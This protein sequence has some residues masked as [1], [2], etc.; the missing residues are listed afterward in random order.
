MRFP[1]HPGLIC[2][3]GLVAALGPVQLFG[4]D[5]SAASGDSGAVTNVSRSGDT[6]TLSVG[7]DRLIVQ[8]CQA[9]MLRVD[10]LPGGKSSPRTPSI[11]TTQWRAV[12]ASID[13]GSDPMTISTGSMIVK[14]SRASG[15]VAVYE[16]RGRLLVA[17]QDRPEGSK[18]GV[19][20]DTAPGSHFYGLKGWEYLDDSK[21]QMEMFPA[22]DAYRIKAGGE[23]NTGGPLLWS[24]RGYGIFVDT[25]GG[26]CRIKSPASVLFS[27]L[28]R[29]DVEYY[30]IVGNPAEIQSTVAGLTGSP[31]MFPKW[32]LG[33]SNS[34]FADMNETLCE[35]NVRGYRSR[36]IP[37]DLYTFDFQWKAWGEDNY[38]EWRWNLQNFPNGPSGAFGKKMAAQGVKLAGIM[39]PRIHVDTT[40][41][42]YA[43]E[44]GFWV[45]GR[46]PYEDYFSKKLVNDLDFSKAECRRWFWDHA[47]GAFDTGIAGWWND[48]ADAWGDTWEGMEMQQAL[49]EGQRAYTRGRQR[50]WSVNRNF[51][52]GAQRYAYATWSGDIDSGF[53][54]MQQQRERL[55]CSVNV[56]QE[57]WGM[58]TG[59]FNNHNR[60]T[61]E[62]Y[63]ECYARWMEFAAFVPIF[64]TH[65]TTYHQPWLFG[66]RAEAA[67]TKAIKLRY[68]LIPYLYSYDRL[69]NQT[70][71]GLVRPLVWDHPDD[72]QCFNRVDAWMFG[73][74]LLAAP[75]VDRGQSRK[76]IYLPAGSWTD[77]FRGTRYV[78]GQTIDYAVDPS[79]WMDIP[80]FIR[81]GA[82]I[83]SMEVMNYVGER[84]LTNVDVDI[85]PDTRPTSFNYYDDDGVTYDYE[86]GSYFQQVMTAQDCGDAVRL[87][88]S[89]RTGSFTPPLRSYTCRI[90]GKVAAAVTVDGRPLARFGDRGALLAGIEEGWMGGS[91]IYGAVTYAKVAAGRARQIVVHE[92]L[93]APPTGD[94]S[95][96]ER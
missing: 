88:I 19:A 92:R 28:S 76:P 4:Q 46:K 74:Y 31:P 30:V 95:T 35:N 7:G 42:H 52:S 26:D 77:Y 22:G 79:T 12:G 25:D 39:K 93:A 18:G 62:E 34:E 57:R 8:V 14:I 86:Q 43:S 56:G 41:G 11:G 68:A 81:Q 51:Y 89:A 66:S 61:G 54:V 69:L 3:L 70:G 2:I 5:V 23:G 59:G 60:V 94:P 75:V 87:T 9:N 82:I 90:H 33:F 21:G 83:P 48:E 65:G 47:R 17:E 16:G 24:N 13:T 36:G 78:G 85:F 20:F 40:Q 6:L 44:H 38:G 73:D 72:P 37:L 58:D 64:R 29:A 32:A 96:S 1:K 71:V 53:G 63:N 84:P 80:L 49:Y 50:V 10:R 45:P 55:M 15:R 67:A 91:D 27:G